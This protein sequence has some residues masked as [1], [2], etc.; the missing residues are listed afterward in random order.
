[1]RVL[2]VA[3]AGAYLSRSD[4]GYIIFLEHTVRSTRLLD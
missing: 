1:M 4:H 3:G 2:G